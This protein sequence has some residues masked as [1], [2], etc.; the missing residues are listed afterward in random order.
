MSETV[1]IL[2]TG[3]HPVVLEGLRSMLETQIQGSLIAKAQPAQQAAD[4]IR[5][6]DWDAVVLELSMTGK[7]GFDVSETSNKRDPTPPF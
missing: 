5:S 3:D 2:L 4:Q 1:R 6:C 7:S